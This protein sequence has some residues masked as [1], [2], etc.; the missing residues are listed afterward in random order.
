[1]DSIAFSSFE[2]VGLGAAELGSSFAGPTE[3]VLRAPWLAGT[4]ILSRQLTG[5]T[6][7]IE[8]NV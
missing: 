7:R 2:Q 8:N 4:L 1:M 5:S 3:H 6:L